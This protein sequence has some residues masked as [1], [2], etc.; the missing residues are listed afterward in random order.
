MASIL[1]WAPEALASV[2]ALADGVASELADGQY[3]LVLNTGPKAGQSV[4][5][6]HA[7]LLAG[8]ELPGFD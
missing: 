5:H 4:F 3:R 1:A 8:G 7:H 6:A 2:I